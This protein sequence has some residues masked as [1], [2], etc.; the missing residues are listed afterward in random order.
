M[1]AGRTA[2]VDTVDE[3]FDR[4]IHPYTLGLL[5]SLPKLEDA[6]AELHPIA[7][8][9]PSMLH[10]PPACAFHPRCLLAKDVC[11]EETPVL[12]NLSDGLTACHFAELLLAEPR[13]D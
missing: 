8:S 3:L 10:P 4:P 11:R 13:S 5:N 2:E 12:R 1:Y 6:G 9:P 7:G